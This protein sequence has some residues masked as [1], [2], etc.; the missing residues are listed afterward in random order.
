MGRYSCGQEFYHLHDSRIHFN[1]D[2][3]VFSSKGRVKGQK[4]D[5]AND[6]KHWE[7]LILEEKQ[8]HQQ[9]QDSGIEEDRDLETDAVE[10]AGNI[11]TPP[12]LFKGLR[13]AF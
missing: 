4:V 8:R 11:L 5:A 6:R 2:F 3:L 9:Q 12:T 13:I 7:K 10:L 1:C